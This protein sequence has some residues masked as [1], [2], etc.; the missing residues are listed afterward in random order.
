MC[1]RDRVNDDEDSSNPE[2]VD[3]YAETYFEDNFLQKDVSLV[4]FDDSLAEKVTQLRVTPD[5]DGLSY[6]QAEALEDVVSSEY[7][8]YGAGQEGDLAANTSSMEYSALY[9]NCLL[10]QSRCV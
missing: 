8:M 9:T 2:F 6:Y 7:L 10:Y 3:S 5:E 1:I 4:F